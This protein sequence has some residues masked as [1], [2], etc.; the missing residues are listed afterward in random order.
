MNSIP[1]ENEPNEIDPT[2]RGGLEATGPW[3]RHCV[4]SSSGNGTSLP[5]SSCQRSHRPSI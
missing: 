3:L 1:S 5:I 2:T 4:V